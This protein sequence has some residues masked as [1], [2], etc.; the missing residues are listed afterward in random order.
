[1]T[2]LGWK[3]LPGTVTLANFATMFGNKKAIYLITLTTLL[4][5]ILRIRILL[6]SGRSRIGF[7]GSSPDHY[8]P[9]P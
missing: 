6:G 3:G 9:I 2:S 1:M 8:T 4:S 7:D 5:S